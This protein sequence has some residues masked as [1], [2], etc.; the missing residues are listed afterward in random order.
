MHDVKHFKS[1]VLCIRQNEK[2][3][4]K[5]FFPLKLQVAT[6]KLLTNHKQTTKINQNPRTLTSIYN[7]RLWSRQLTTVNFFCKA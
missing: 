6:Q 5:F 1:S 4:E 7:N 3:K 2:Y